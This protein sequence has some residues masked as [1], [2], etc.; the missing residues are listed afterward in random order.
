MKNK[1]LPSQEYLNSILSYDKESGVLSWKNRTFDSPFANFWNKRYAGKPVTTIS[2]A[3]YLF[4]GINKSKYLAHRVIWKMTTG[5]DALIVDHINR[6]RL[7]NR[8]CNLREASTSL[9]MHNKN[10][11]GCR[12]PQG[13]QPNKSRFM[14]RI[15]NKGKSFYLG[16][17][18]TPEEASAVYCHAANILYPPP[19]AAL[20]DLGA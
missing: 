5:Q 3:G 9:S 2:S 11:N 12:L 13:V 20:P 10:H 7:D 19:T 16:T 1:P 18:A 14:A 8:L 17:Y 4:V 15:S 6:N